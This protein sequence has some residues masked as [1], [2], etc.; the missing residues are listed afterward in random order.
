M[1]ADRLFDSRWRKQPAE[2]TEEL[3][4]KKR[5]PFNFHRGHYQLVSIFMRHH[6]RNVQ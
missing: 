4:I 3:F 6:H 5:A 1:R 2:A